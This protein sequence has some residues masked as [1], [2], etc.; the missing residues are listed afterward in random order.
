MNVESIVNDVKGRVEPI[1]ARGQDV[2]FSGFEVLKSANGIVVDGFTGVYKANYEAGKTLFGA[3]QTSFQKVK[4]DGVKAVAS[5][6][7]AYL[8]EGKDTF[9]SAFNTSVDV[10]VKTGDD[11]VK[12]MKQGVETLSAKIKGEPVM[13][14]KAKSTAK[15]ATSSVRK[16]AK[17]TASKVEKKVNKTAAK[18][19]KAADDLT[20]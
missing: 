6:P 16:T 20:R 3:A 15:Q 13:V 11:L 14:A 18:A 7:A 10:F 4:T 8:P 17:S 2:V 9:V 19:E 5:N 1:V 12:T